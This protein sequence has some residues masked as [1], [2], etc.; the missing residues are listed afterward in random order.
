MYVNQNKNKLK[1][2]KLEESG[3]VLNPK[4]DEKSSALPHPAI[5]FTIIIS[6]SYQSSDPLVSPVTKFLS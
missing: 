3:R 5:M 2:I 1:I 4:R 6:K